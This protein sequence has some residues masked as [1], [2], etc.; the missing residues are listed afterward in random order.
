MKP[1]PA[2]QRKQGFSHDLNL[3]ENRRRPRATR[4]D[5]LPPKNG[6]VGSTRPAEPEGVRGRRAFGGELDQSETSFKYFLEKAEK[7][8]RR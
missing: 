1:R 5:D 2:S 6:S 8:D 3:S 7:S 4:E